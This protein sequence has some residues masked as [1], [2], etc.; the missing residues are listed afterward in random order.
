[1][2]A[3]SISQPWRCAPGTSTKPDSIFGCSGRVIPYGNMSATI[4]RIAKSLDSLPTLPV[5]ALRIGEVIQSDTA[6]AN[7]L[8]Q[9]L[10]TDPG[11]SA[12]LLR[13]VNSPNFGI[14]G[15]VSDVARAIPFVGFAALHQLVVGVGVMDA[16]KT[17]NAKVDPKPLWLHSLVVATAARE[18]ATTIRFAD[19]GS[20]FTAGLLHDMGK[21]ALAKAEPDKFAQLCAAVRGGASAS[22]AEAALELPAHG[23]IGA[24]LARQWRLPATLAAPI[25]RHHAGPEDLAKLAANLRAIT[26][27]VAVADVLSQ[28]CTLAQETDAYTEDGDVHALAIMD[29]R[30]ISTAQLDE[31]CGRVK[32]GLDKSN[33]FLSLLS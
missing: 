16:L 14:P 7:Q 23:E 15:G 30:G 24:R 6:N 18:L 2:G 5:V 31:V 26:E 9:L 33:A 8:A 1:M 13:L 21:I 27:I 29:A 4:E 22:D 32:A 11:I 17:T 3:W 12:K 25:E 28:R 10:R 20:C 19:A